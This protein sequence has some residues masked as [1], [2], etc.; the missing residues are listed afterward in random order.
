[1]RTKKVLVYLALS[2]IIAFQVGGDAYSFWDL[3]T[4]TTSENVTIGDWLSVSTWGQSAIDIINYIDANI[5]NDP[6]LQS[7]YDQSGNLSKVSIRIE[8]LTID[9]ISW[10][11]VGIGTKTPTTS[12]GFIQIVDRAETGGSFVHA[13]LPPAPT[14]VDPYID[15]NYFLVNDVNNT[16]TNNQYSIRLNYGVSMQTDQPINSLTEVSFYASR[17]LSSVS[18]D[19]PV[20]SR[21]F[22]VEVSL[23]NSNWTTI[24]SN[25]SVT[26]PSNSY[27][28]N[29]YV[30]SVPANLSGQDLYVRINY[31]GES[32]G[33]VKDA[34]YSRLVIDGL[35]F[36]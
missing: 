2:F 1:M 5:S 27:A 7:I 23:N 18:D 30:Y 34:A 16:I 28:F 21:G 9:D 15:Y 32:I 13:I 19:I 26:P 33:K 17:G 11:I 36:N 8:N 24:G 14:G 29:Q 22:S 31:S 3:P 10:D 25:S 6:N 12:L 35:E 20:V 4:K